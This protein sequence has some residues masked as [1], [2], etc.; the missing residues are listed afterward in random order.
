M[1]D[2]VQ[3]FRIVA[4]LDR[5]FDAISTPAEMDRWWTLRSNGSR[6]VGAAWELGFGPGHDWQ[7]TVTACEPASTFELTLTR[8]DPDWTDTRIRF[9][10]SRTAG[11]TQV[12]FRHQGWPAANDHFRVSCHCWALYLRLLRR[13]VEHGEFVPY[14]RRLDA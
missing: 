8:A 13:H 1:P 10:L 11:G 12:R 9:D 7:A 3:D 2:I 14:H 5:V 6:Q 4:S